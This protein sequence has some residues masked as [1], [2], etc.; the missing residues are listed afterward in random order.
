MTKGEREA[1]IQ[2]IADKIM[3][4][5]YDKSNEYEKSKEDN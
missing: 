2:R 1:T 4:L 5:I 3:K